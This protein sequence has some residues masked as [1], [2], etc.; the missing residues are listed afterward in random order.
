VGVFSYPVDCSIQDYPASSKTTTLCQ[1]HPLNLAPLFLWVVMPTQVHLLP[2]VGSDPA[3]PEVYLL[4]SPLQDP[5]SSAALDRIP[6]QLKPKLSDASLVLLQELDLLPLLHSLFK[7]LLLCLLL[8]LLLKE[9]FHLL[10]MQLFPRLLSSMALLL[11]SRSLLPSSST[12]SKLPR[13][14]TRVPGI[15]C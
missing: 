8:Q 5:T 14:M 13:C 7:H 2:L 9:L 11:I 10:P 3:C 1:A 15:A 4:P 6:M 12:S